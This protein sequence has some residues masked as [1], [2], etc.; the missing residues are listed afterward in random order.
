[1]GKRK[2]QAPVTYLDGTLDKYNLKNRTPEE[3]KAFAKK[4]A[5]T[6]KKN[7]QEKLALQ[8][9]MRTLLSMRVSSDKQKQVLKQIGFEDAELTNKT[10]LMTALFKKGLTGDVSAIKEIT[11][12]MD[13]LELFESGK[14]VRQQPVII[15][16]VPTGEPTPITE[17]D[18]KDIWKAE[19]GIPLTDTK[20]MEE[21]DT[22]D[23]EIWNEDDWGNEVYDG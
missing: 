13:K 20:N 23:S 14:D 15:N 6:K 7:K 8:K 1:M 3:R 4:A 21:W 10:L 2:G 11:D 9:V 18:E 12:M 19:N 5:E 17:Q 22:D 16:L